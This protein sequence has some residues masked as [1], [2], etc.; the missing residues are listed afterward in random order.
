TGYNSRGI[1]A[2]H[3]GK[4]AVGNDIVI[5]VEKD[6]TASGTG[7]IG[8][9]TIDS[10]ITVGGNVAG[11]YGGIDASGSDVDVTGDVQ[12]TGSGVN[13]YGVTATNL[14]EIIIGGDVRSNEIGAY[15]WSEDG[16]TPS[17]ITIN[18]VI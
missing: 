4:A 12:S 5:N 13:T 18:G 2:Y 17:M 9:Q 8:V 14:S 10:N 11:E 1:Y 16:E 15:I 6:I 3:D 7:S